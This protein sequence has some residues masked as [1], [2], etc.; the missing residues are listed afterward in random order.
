MSTLS[1]FFRERNFYPTHYFLDLQGISGEFD[2]FLF[3]AKNATKI[4][5]N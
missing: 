1:R 2:M 4:K 5:R 3:N